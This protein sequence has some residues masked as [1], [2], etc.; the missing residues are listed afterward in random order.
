MP[1]HNIKDRQELIKYLS[2]KSVDLRQ[3]IVR[4]T[5][6]AGGGHIGGGLSMTDMLVVLYN[7]IM[8]IDP[9]NPK[10]EDRDRL[11]LSKG[12]G[13]IGIC[14]VLCDCGYYPQ[15]LMENFNQFLSPF[16]MHP[17][18]NKVPGID[19]STG[20]LGHGL[21]VCV[22]LALGARL[23]NSKFRIFCVL[24]DGECNEGSVWEAAMAA[25][26]YK[27]G[28]IV[29]LVD[30]NKL[31]IDGPVKE[32]M[33]IEP[34]EDKWK[35]FGWSTKVVDGHDIGALI[36]VLENVPPVDSD[37]PT[38]IICNTIKGKGVSFMENQSKWHY[39]GIDEQLEKTAIADIEKLRRG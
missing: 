11:I 12:H 16:G 19:M 22:G 5:V 29:A 10:W 32:I 17:D 14:P 33:D 39:G 13:G 31:M 30:R 7:H 23:N 20:S 34:F 9:K 35:A 3:M 27:L 26:H 28:R 38:C 24:G 36:D 1:L 18:M 8:N 6:T 15:S 2:N 25:T 4:L 21:S 37:K